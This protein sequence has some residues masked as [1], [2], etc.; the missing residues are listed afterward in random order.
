MD[1]L[2]KLG[3]PGRWV[4]TRASRR[5]LALLAA[6]ALVGA[7][8]A[9]AGA[10]A[11]GPTARALD[12]TP[13]VLTRF[14]GGP[15]VNVTRQLS[16]VKAPFEARDD[17]S[18]VVSI[19]A[20]AVDDK[21]RAV[22]HAMYRAPLPAKRVQGVL[23]VY[24]DEQDLMPPGNYT[25]TF[26]SVTDAAGNVAVYDGAALAALGDPTVQVRNPQ[27]YDVTGPTLVNGV[28]LTPEV[29]LSDHHPGTDQ[30]P[31]VAVRL[32]VEDT[33]GTVVSGPWVSRAEFCLRA[34]PETC[35]W[36]VDEQRVPHQSP[37]LLTLAGQLGDDAP[38]V[39]HLA[40]LLLIDM[41]SNYTVLTSVDFGGDTDFGRYFPSTTI[42]VT[43]GAA[44]AARPAPAPRGG[45][46]AYSPCDPEAQR[47]RPAAKAAAR[48]LDVTPP[49]LTRFDA[50][51]ELNVDAQL[52]TPRVRFEARDDRSGIVCIVA[53][54][55]GTKGDSSLYAT[56]EPA[57]PARH[58]SSV[59]GDAGRPK[60]LMPPGTYTFV[61]A[62]V[63]DAA[64]NGA[65]YDAAALAALGNTTVKLRNPQGYDLQP[66]ALVSGIIL[67]PQ[68]SLSGHHPGTD[69]P[70]YFSLK[71]GVEDRG[72]SMTSGLRSANVALCTLG[73]SRRCIDGW[74]YMELPHQSNGLFTVA[75]Q[76]HRD[77][78]SPPGE[79]H[80]CSVSLT[81]MSRNVSRYDSIECGGDTD[82]SR[83]FP[84]VVVTLTP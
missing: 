12:T 13:P 41:A 66:P 19:Y 20:E 53:R 62:V 60:D 55:Q 9:T 1:K 51:P 72:N 77:N 23:A 5:V 2:G 47:A 81:D 45:G 74:M 22:L 8:G 63:Y 67:T 14:D 32:G 70:P 82:F 30:R 6:G 15:A 16:T 61:S 35:L 27:G 31:Y 84:S 7:P 38:G 59:L 75:G 29:S 4:A 26:A 44:P 37:A 36:A 46:A 42:T 76:P 50:D 56:I 52:A 69:Q 71:L 34:S 18:G 54:A 24:D 17:Q 80:L 33:G 64:G 57:L 83:Y 48:G 79:Y 10:A 40:S 28:I 11:P 49:V 21:G 78:S 68:V 39:Y 58:L 3:K 73:Q 65:V 43:Q 25:F